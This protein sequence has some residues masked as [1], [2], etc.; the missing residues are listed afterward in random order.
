[1]LGAIN[2]IKRALTFTYQILIAGPQ[3]L[4][5]LNTSVETSGTWCRPD[6]VSWK[7]TL[8]ILRNS[9]KCKAN[10][11]ANDRSMLY[12]LFRLSPTICVHPVIADLL[13][14]Y[15]FL[16][17]KFNTLTYSCS[18]N[19]NRTWCTH[20][21]MCMLC[22]LMMQTPQNRL[23]NAQL[24]ICSLNSMPVALE[25]IQVLIPPL[26]HCSRCNMLHLTCWRRVPTY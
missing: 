1:M 26:L 20:L 25:P 10:G 2:D 7:C 14:A 9:T 15:M 24:H 8:Q 17:S 21:I 3:T 18:S 11:R 6:R 19:G 23:Q 16:A 13:L 5:F 12:Q 22:V 4:Q